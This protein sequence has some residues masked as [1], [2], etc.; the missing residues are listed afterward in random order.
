[1]NKKGYLVS[2]N[3]NG[4]PLPRWTT[5][6]S[7][8]DFNYAPSNHTKDT[9]SRKKATLTQTHQA[10]IE[11]N[12]RGNDTVKKRKEIDQSDKAFQKGI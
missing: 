12:R 1:M 8:P 11:Q 5:V 10:R 9:M 2:N 6:L 4:K 7:S 3:A